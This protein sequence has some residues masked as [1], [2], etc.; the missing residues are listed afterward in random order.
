ML[1]RKPRRNWRRNQTQI[2]LS[3]AAKLS[4][5]LGPPH[6]PPQRANVSPPFAFILLV[7]LRSV[8]D[9]TVLNTK[10]SDDQS[11]AIPP[12]NSQLTFEPSR[13]RQ[14]V[15]CGAT[16]RHPSRLARRSNLTRD[17]SITRSARFNT[18]AGIVTPIA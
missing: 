6:L 14:H 11:P 12:I 16:S 3:L 13:S 4:R 15:R 1:G 5:K 8:A 9:S 17:Y 18:C 7:I 2:H 10:A